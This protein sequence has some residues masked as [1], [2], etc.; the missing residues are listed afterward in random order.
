MLNRMYVYVFHAVSVLVLLLLV[1]CTKDV[2]GATSVWHIGSD[3][4][5]TYAYT[6]LVCLTLCLLYLQRLHACTHTLREMH[7]ILG[8]HT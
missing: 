3:S 4:I 7:T 8:Y 2:L 6:C 1:V 5:R